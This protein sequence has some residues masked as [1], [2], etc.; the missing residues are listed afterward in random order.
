MSFTLRGRP[1]ELDVKEIYRYCI[2]EKISYSVRW[3]EQDVVEL[4]L[5]EPIPFLD[6]GTVYRGP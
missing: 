1:D 3:P 5:D 2:S 6:N 4:T